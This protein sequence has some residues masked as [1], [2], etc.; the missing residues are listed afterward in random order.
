MIRME[1]KDV[2]CSLE[3]DFGCTI[4]ILAYILE[5]KETEFLKIRAGEKELTLGQGYKL[6]RLHAIL[7]QN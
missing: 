3:V 4:A 7:C 2:I 1:L 5:L 6:I